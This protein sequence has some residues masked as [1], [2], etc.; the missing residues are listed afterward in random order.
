MQKNKREEMLER[1]K[2]RIGNRQGPPKTIAFVALGPHVQ[3]QSAIDMLVQRSKQDSDGEV[4]VV[5][6]FFFITA[7]FLFENG[8][9]IL[10]ITC[11]LFHNWDMLIIS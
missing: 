5:S 3:L 10:K 6:P 9:V 4:F 7:F 1:A 8:V 11:S 2:M